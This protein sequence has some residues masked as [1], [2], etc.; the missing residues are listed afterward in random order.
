LLSPNDPFVG[1]P[2]F[3]RSLEFKLGEV[4]QGRTSQYFTVRATPVQRARSIL[5]QLPEQ[6]AVVEEV[7]RAA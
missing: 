1:S 5:E 3:F 2:E 7:A 4:I 6:A